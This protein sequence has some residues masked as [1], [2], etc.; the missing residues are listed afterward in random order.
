MACREERKKARPSPSLFSSPPKRSVMYWLATRSAVVAIPKWRSLSAFLSS[1]PFRRSFIASSPCLLYS[2]FLPSSLRLHAFLCF[3]LCVFL[4][5]GRD[6]L[7]RLWVSRSAFYVSR[8]WCVFTFFPVFY[9]G[10]YDWSTLGYA[11]VLWFD[12]RKLTWLC[13]LAND[14]PYWQS[15]M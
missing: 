4:L 5:E 6:R 8:Q 12:K 15:K 9:V 14:P 2:S 7:H 11:S 13:R 3:F 10:W 1:P